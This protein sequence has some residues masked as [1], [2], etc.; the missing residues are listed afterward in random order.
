MQWITTLCD[1]YYS[2]FT[3][4]ETEQMGKIGGTMHSKV[5][6][7][8]KRKLRDQLMQASWSILAWSNSVAFVVSSFYINTSYY[9]FFFHIIHFQINILTYEDQDRG[10]S[11]SKSAK[12]IDNRNR[13]I[14]SAWDAYAKLKWAINVKS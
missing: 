5:I 7:L 6:D 13:W 2:H 4:D 8:V 10:Y 14:L 9:S 12:M 1:Y 3:V 11:T